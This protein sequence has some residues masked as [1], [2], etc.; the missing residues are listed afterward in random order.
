MTK[1]YKKKD[2]T[3]IQRNQD[4]Q[5]LK[6]TGMHCH[7]QPHHSLA[8]DR[9]E[10]SKRLPMKSH[11]FSA[12]IYSA[13]WSAG[14]RKRAF[15]WRMFGSL[16]LNKNTSRYGWTR[17]CHRENCHCCCQAERWR[18]CLFRKPTY[19]KCRQ[20]RKLCLTHTAM[21]F[22]ISTATSEGF[23]V[24]YLKNVV[25]AYL[26]LVN[27]LIRI[28]ALGM[29]QLWIERYFHWQKLAFHSVHT[30]VC[31]KYFKCLKSCFKDFMSNIKTKC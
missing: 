1:I 22:C 11:V 26:D 17:H 14:I 6:P 29:K 28:L 21:D 19:L 24:S 7:T 15:L 12:S 13:F 4:P 5:Y 18:P 2:L 20:K 9:S 10:F 16:Y 8:I 23:R 27:I 3:L 30:C 25:K 31:M